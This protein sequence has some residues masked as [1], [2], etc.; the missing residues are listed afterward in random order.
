MDRKFVPIRS[1]APAPSRGSEGLGLYEPLETKK[2]RVGVSVACNACRRKK[3]RVSAF[4]DPSL[5]PVLCIALGLCVITMSS[6]SSSQCDGL[7]PA[8]SNCHEQTARCTYRDGGPELP[9]GAKRI[10]LEMV[11][12]LSSLPPDEATRLLVSLRSETNAYVVLSV[13]RDETES[14]DPASSVPGTNSASSPFDFEA[15]NPIAYPVTPPPD[16]ISA[17]QESYLDLTPFS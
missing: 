11:E 6:N 17:E 2:R 8:C 12:M 1:A 5:L 14:R 15:Q 9:D 4:T 13:L 7:R 10:V 16:P 3:I